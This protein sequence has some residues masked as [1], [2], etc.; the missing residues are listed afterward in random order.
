MAT[1]DVS[2][3]VG[4]TMPQFNSGINDYYMAHITVDTPDFQIKIVPV[5]R[6]GF[7]RLYPS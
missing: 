3:I 6:L 4:K 5:D 7:R 1:S 2:G